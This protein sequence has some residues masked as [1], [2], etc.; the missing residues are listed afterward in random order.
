M[1]GYVCTYV[2]SD[3]RYGKR[4]C[5]LAVFSSVYLPIAFQYIPNTTHSNIQSKNTH[6]SKNVRTF[7]ALSLCSSLVGSLSSLPPAVPAAVVVEVAPQKSSMFSIPVSESMA[8]DPRGGATVV[9]LPRECV[10][11]VVVVVVAVAVVAVLAVV[12]ALALA[13]ACL[14]GADLFVFL[15]APDAAAA[16]AA[17][18]AAEEAIR[19]AMELVAPPVLSSPAR[20]GLVLRPPLLLPV[21]PPGLPG[22]SAFAASA[23]A[24]RCRAMATAVAGDDD[25]RPPPPPPPD[26]PP[27]PLPPR[28]E[29]RLDLPPVGVDIAGGWYMYMPR[30]RECNQKQAG[31]GERGTMALRLPCS[32]RKSIINSARADLPGIAGAWMGCSAVQCSAGRRILPVA[33]VA[34][35][36]KIPRPTQGRARQ[37]Q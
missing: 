34:K 28:D 3:G 35:R 7:L 21:P 32:E 26:L 9:R 37:G 8:T 31:D 4:G 19:S 22:S 6:C 1:G 29:R 18:A 17:A 36:R 15:L 2:V 24:S 23:W 12:A 13:L 14:G 20:R 16:A 25:G 27:L 30:K 10:V 11:V 5:T 33:S